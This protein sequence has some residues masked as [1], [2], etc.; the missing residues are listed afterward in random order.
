MHNIKCTLLTILTYTAQ[1]RYAA[2]TSTHLQNFL[3]FL[4]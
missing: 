2:V 1:W 4:S 3:I